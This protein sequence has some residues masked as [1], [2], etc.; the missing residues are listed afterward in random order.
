MNSA[1]PWSDRLLHGDCINLMQRMPEASIDLIL[2]D[3]PYLVDYRSRDGRRF[4]ND[5][6]DDAGWLPTAF[7]QMYR[8]LKPGSLCVSFYG[9]HRADTFLSAWKTAGFR[10]VG[11]IVWHKHYASRTGL[12]RATHEAAYLLAKGKPRQPGQA[13]PDVLPWGTY[14]GNRLHP[15]QKPVAA[16]EPVIEA[17]SRPGELVLDPFAGSASTAMAAQK[18]DRRYV[19]I[20]LEW[21]YFQNA[22]RRLNS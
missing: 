11:H 9:W 8:I 4:Q 22:W 15:C 10:L 1:Q 20:E 18:L 12:T 19:A 5:N 13:I 2:T 14:T 3:P 7:A 16:F 6:P 17:F 21:Q